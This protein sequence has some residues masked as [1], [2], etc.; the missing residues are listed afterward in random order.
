MRKAITTILTLSFLIAMIPCVTGCN[1][2]PVIWY[3]EPLTFY[4]NAIYK[5]GPDYNKDHQYSVAPELKDPDNEVG[6]LIKDLDGDGIEELLIGFNDGS[7]CTKFTDVIVFYPD[8]D[9]GAFKLLGG[10]GGSYIYLCGADNVICMENTFGVTA[11]SKTF[12]QYQGGT[13][14]NFTEID[15]EGKYLPTTWELTSFNN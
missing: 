4:K 15:G 3:A 14:G 8:L 12:M 2:S 13:I 11:A 1:R 6:Y 7:N 10:T 9:I 5:D